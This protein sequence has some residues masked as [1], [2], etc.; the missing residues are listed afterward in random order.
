MSQGLFYSIHANTDCGG[1][2]ISALEDSTPNEWVPPTDVYECIDKCVNSASCTGVVQRHSDNACLWRSGTSFA[3]HV[4]LPRHDCYQ[5]RS[6]VVY[7]RVALVTTEFGTEACVS[8]DKDY[9][10]E[11]GQSQYKDVQSASILNGAA[12]TPTVTLVIADLP[13]GG[14]WKMCYCTNYGYCDDMTDYTVEAGVL[15][16][17][18]A[19]GDDFYEE[20]TAE[21]GPSR[22]NQS[23][24][25]GIL[26]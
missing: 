11:V 12:V 10:H 2:V 25:E 19:D 18:G 15:T 23:I 4:D 14:V 13:K 7:D 22:P 8:D 3:T 9:S 17:V 26:I 6:P 5:M 24:P 16:V 21:L 1:S 20:L